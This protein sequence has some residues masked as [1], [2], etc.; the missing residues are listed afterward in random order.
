MNLLQ[1][2]GEEIHAVFDGFEEAIVV[3]QNNEPKFM[4]D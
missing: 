2:A 1:E 3:V 4:N